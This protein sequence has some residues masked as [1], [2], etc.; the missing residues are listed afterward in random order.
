[1]SV[2][3]APKAGNQLVLEAPNPE[4]GKPIEIEWAKLGSEQTKLKIS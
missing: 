2:E 3:A 1:V 4:G